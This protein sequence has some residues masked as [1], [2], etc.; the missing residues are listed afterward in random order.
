MFKHV[1]CA[2][3]K[4]CACVCE[5][6]RE[7][8]KMGRKII[9]DSIY[10]GGEGRDEGVSVIH[11]EDKLNE[12]HHHHKHFSSNI[13]EKWVNQK[14]IKKE[15]NGP[16]LSFIH[17]IKYGVLKWLFG[18]KSKTFWGFIEIFSK[19]RW[20]NDCQ[21]LTK[22]E[23]KRILEWLRRERCSNTSKYEYV[24]C[25]YNITFYK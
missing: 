14:N 1:K 4:V 18:M 11:M 10:R 15:V 23:K 24:L 2:G 3:T 16:H 25:L 5:W 17:W 6:G 21:V 9:I 8:E 20:K 22:E 13:L 12:P 7:R 19:G